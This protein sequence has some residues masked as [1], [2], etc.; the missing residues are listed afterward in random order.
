[1]NTNTLDKNNT[2]ELIE[3]IKAS[4]QVNECSYQKLKANNT[5]GLKM[6]EFR[7]TLLM[8]EK[9]CQSLYIGRKNSRH[10]FSSQIAL[11]IGQLFE[12][13]PLVTDYDKFEEF[14]QAIGKFIAIKGQH[15]KELNYEAVIQPIVFRAAAAQSATV[16][17]VS[18]NDNNND[19]NNSNGNNN[20]VIT[21]DRKAPC[22]VVSITPGW[23]KIATKPRVRVN[24]L[25]VK[26]II[27]DQD[28]RFIVTS[29]RDVYFNDVYIDSFRTGKF[30]E[31]HTNVIKKFADIEQAIITNNFKLNTASKK[32]HLI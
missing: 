23:F 19:N 6:K 3:L 28:I 31:R 14:K 21:V 11:V 16:T 18:V 27:D 29:D 5:L 20:K 1:M 13:L 32:L 30:Q 2:A 12:L 15:C 24:A 25:Y 26:I 17:T 7:Q 22:Q 4:I 9:T 8:F 10:D